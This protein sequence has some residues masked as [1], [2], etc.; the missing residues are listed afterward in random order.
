MH[1]VRVSVKTSRFE[2]RQRAKTPDQGSVRKAFARALTLMHLGGQRYNC[3]VGQVKFRASQD[4]LKLGGRIHGDAVE[5][6]GDPN[7]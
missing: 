2:D 7:Q 1:K 4:K 3:F 5:A 6:Y